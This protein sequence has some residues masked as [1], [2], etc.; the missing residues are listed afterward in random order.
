MTRPQASRTCRIPIPRSQR[1]MADDSSAPRPRTSMIAGACRDMPIFARRL[2]DWERRREKNERVVAN[3]LDADRRHLDAGYQAI[4]TKYRWRV[5]AAAGGGTARPWWLISWT[6]S[7]GAK[8]ERAGRR[9]PALRVVLARLL[10]RDLA[11]DFAARVR[12]GVNVDVVLAG[13]QVGRLCV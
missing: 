5:A 1:P 2:P 10:L 11:A 9:R 12:R 13:H 4:V 3:Q 6:A 8:S 7:L